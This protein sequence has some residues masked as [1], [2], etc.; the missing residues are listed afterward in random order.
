MTPVEQ[1]PPL[2]T[3]HEDDEVWL[4]QQHTTLSSTIPVKAP[5]QDSAPLS[6]QAV[7][8]SLTPV[9]FTSNDIENDHTSLMAAHQHPEAAEALPLL[10]LPGV[11]HNI[12]SPVEDMEVDPEQVA[13]DNFVQPLQDSDIDFDIEDP[14]PPRPRTPELIKYASVI[15][16]I[17]APPTFARLPY[18]NRNRFYEA[19]AAAM[20]IPESQLVLLHSMPHPPEDLETSQTTPMIAQV[21]HELAPGAIH[22]YVLLDVEFHAAMPTLSPEVQRST[23]LLP[24]HLTR[25]QILRIN[26]VHQYCERAKRSQTGCLVWHNGQLVHTDFAGHITLFHGDYLKIALPPDDRTAEDFTTRELAA[27][28]W[29]GEEMYTDFGEAG[30]PFLPDHLP[31]VPPDISTVYV[32]PDLIYEDDSALLQTAKSAPTDPRGKEV[33]RNPLLDVTNLAGGFSF[34]A[35]GLLKDHADSWQVSGDTTTPRRNRNQDAPA[36]FEDQ[37]EQLLQQDTFSHCRLADGS[38][39][40]HTWYLD[41][42]RIPNQEEDRLVYLSTNPALWRRQILNEWP[43]VVLPQN[44]ALFHVATPAPHNRFQGQELHILVTQTPDLGTSSVLLSVEFPPQ[45]AGYGYRIAVAHSRIASCHTIHNAARCQDVQEIPEH[46][47]TTVSFDNTEWSQHRLYPLEDG[48]HLAIQVTIR[49]GAESNNDSGIEISP[50]VPF[51]LSEEED[52]TLDSIGGHTTSSTTPEDD[53]GDQDQPPPKRARTLCLSKLL[54]EGPP[55]S[56]LTSS[57]TTTHRFG[58]VTNP[59][60]LLLDP[61]L[62][63]PDLGRSS[64][65]VDLL[66]FEEQN[67]KSKIL[68]DISIQLHALP[69][70]LRVPASA[71]DLLCRQPIDFAGT[72]HHI[73]IFLDGSAGDKGAGWSIVVIITDGIE[74]RFLG[75]L[76]GQVALASDDPAWLGAESTDNIAAELTAFAQAQLLATFFHQYNVVLRPDLSLSRTVASGTTTCKSNPRLAKLLRN[77]QRWSADHHSIHEVRGHTGQPWNDLADELAKHSVNNPGPDAPPKLQTLQRFLLEEHDHN[78]AWLQDMQ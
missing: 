78:W 36:T 63:G 3:P 8:S 48:N 45:T 2:Q 5:E 73:E 44:W 38:T 19:A 53:Q 60:V 6:F 13:I 7:S 56:S 34:G 15:F 25:S 33:S 50:T 12:D 58:H 21:V 28:C 41:H 32:L 77:L 39:L 1:A 74:E 17:N 62:P 24:K 66:W 46:H 68:S 9:P 37:L 52:H 40:A 20:Q 71:Y 67:W 65:Q 59:V 18:G 27:I 16:S 11:A 75:C 42:H 47:C 30:R 64:D 10:H 72:P 57:P 70:G 4:T 49:Q 35:H 69:D 54:P 31:E 43:D 14:T 22:R 29:R 61:V 76:W 55:P 51:E 26:A 23:K